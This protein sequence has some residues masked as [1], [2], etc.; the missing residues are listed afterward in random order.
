MQQTTS[1]RREKIS[2][3]VK[4]LALPDVIPLMQG[5]RLRRAKIN[6]AEVGYSALRSEH[7]GELEFGAACKD[8]EHSCVVHKHCAVLL[9]ELICIAEASGNLHI[10]YFSPVSF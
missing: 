8:L 4:L 1:S 2:T 7:E 3:L 10:F 6:T 5:T 9:V